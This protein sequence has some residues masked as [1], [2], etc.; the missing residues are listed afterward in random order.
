MEFKELPREVQK[1]I[2]SC[3]TLMHEIE[4]QIED[5]LIQDGYTKKLIK[6]CNIRYDEM[7]KEL[8]FIDND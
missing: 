3:T 6:V 5:D 8:D 1:Y 2:L 7:K 4:E